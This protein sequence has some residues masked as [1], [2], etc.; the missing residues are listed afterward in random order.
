SLTIACASLWRGTDYNNHE[1]QRFSFVFNSKRFPFSGGYELVIV[2]D[3]TRSFKHKEADLRSIQR[4]QKPERRQTLALHQN[5]IFEFGKSDQTFIEVNDRLLALQLE[6][7]PVII[8]LHCFHVPSLGVTS[9]H[10]RLLAARLS[11]RRRATLAV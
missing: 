6:L 2:G 8:R 10:P 3:H 7:C 5:V 9:N 1:G 4:L 11:R